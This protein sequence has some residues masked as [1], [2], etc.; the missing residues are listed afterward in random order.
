MAGDTLRNRASGFHS[1]VRR[2]L[3][4]RLIA[5]ERCD[6]S[7]RDKSGMCT[8]P[9]A[10]PFSFLFFFCFL[11]RDEFKTTE[12]SSERVDNDGEDS[13]CGEIQ[14]AIYLDK[15]DLLSISS[16]RDRITRTEIEGR[17][18]YRKIPRTISRGRAGC[19]KI[20]IISLY[21]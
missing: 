18:E 9:R 14:S 21:D 19:R 15:G 16:S 17:D 12:P 8:Q 5:I 10:I 1:A 11:S 13:N 2:N 20:M 6:K 3:I 4:R 7:E